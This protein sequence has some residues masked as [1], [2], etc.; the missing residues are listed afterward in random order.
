MRIS[1][2]IIFIL[3][4]LFIIMLN[5][6]NVIEI[7]KNKNKLEDIK[8][9]LDTPS[10]VIDVVSYAGDCQ[11]G[12]LSALVL[13]GVINKEKPRVYLAGN[14]SAK[15]VSLEEIRI[16]MLKLGANELNYLERDNLP[17]H[18][19]YIAFWTLF[20]KYQAEIK[21]IYIYDTDELL[22]DSIN[23]AAMLAGRNHGVAV[24]QTL[25]EALAAG[26][27][28]KNRKVVNICTEFG[29]DLTVGNVGINR[30]IEQNMIEGSNQ[31][32]VFIAK[33]GPR[34]EAALS[35]PTFYDLAVATDSL[36][37]HVDPDFDSQLELQKKILNHFDDNILVIGWPGINVE[38][39]Y[40][41]SVSECNKEVVCADWCYSNGS[42]LGAY[43]NFKHEE[44]LYAREYDKEVLS[45]KVYISFLVSD[46]DAWHYATREFLAYWESDI[47]GTVPIGWSIPSL[48]AEFNPLWLEKIYSEATPNDEIM[49]GVAG[50]SYIQ[51]HYMSDTAFKTW[52]Y[53][54]KNVLSSLGITT[55][56]YWDVGGD[57]YV[58]NSKR[59]KE[60]C[61]IVKPN[62]VYIG[63]ADTIN[64]YFMID[65]TVCLTSVGVS[66]V[67]GTHNKEEM[68]AA[69]DSNVARTAENTPVFINLN[70]EAWG[71]GITTIV[72]T[73]NELTAREDG[74]KY[75]FVLPYELA[76]LIRSYEKNGASGKIKDEDKVT[77]QTVEYIPN[78][79][80]E[81][82]ILFEDSDSKINEGVSTR[83][84]DNN[85]YWVYKLDVNCRDTLKLILSITGQ[86]TV[87]VSKDGA[88][89]VKVV[90]R[91]YSSGDDSIT[92]DVL[93]ALKD[94]DGTV[95]VK[96][97]DT[98][99]S[100]G[101]GASLY[102]M[103]V[104]Y[105]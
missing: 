31:D 30:W 7:N 1:K 46:G 42:L 94:Y 55:V 53:D 47:R 97:E 18:N 10:E 49:Q 80:S 92:I 15:N 24:D 6:C 102:K 12:K 3:T 65:D 43:E 79:E 44:V 8:L 99:K 85:A 59:L 29:F 34:D 70:V 17:S 74:Y 89:W 86:Y 23:V 27:Y 96:F 88:T 72:E 71:E 20:N 39:I 91:D 38:G 11:S 14:E 48:F 45:D 76:N 68:I 82:T 95:Y 25:Y 90:S 50:V 105:K 75:E 77:L 52:C 84:A 21:S 9:N 37:Y 32:F 4:L 40:V 19:K 100:D 22:S 16:E 103:T 81:H 13:Q 83:F 67:R 41:R 57:A 66:G 64:E 101:F 54:T 5:G 56:N 51:P 35:Y 61:E 2:K 33:T 60:Y 98:S 69:I 104:V 26:G 87:S 36:I 93:Q 58:E 78:S 73:I 62:A 63:H 28:A